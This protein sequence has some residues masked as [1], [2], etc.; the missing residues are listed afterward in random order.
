MKRRV[1]LG[2][3]ASLPLLGNMSP[4]FPAPAPILPVPK[5]IS[6]KCTTNF[7]LSQVLTLGVLEAYE[8]INE[9][10][11]VELSVS[12]DDGSV[13]NFTCDNKTWHYETR[14]CESHVV[15]GKDIIVYYCNQSDEDGHLA[16]VC[17]FKNVKESFGLKEL[18]L[19]N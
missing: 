12:Y 10:P 8:D 19:G 16:T 5:I 9:P 4:Y 3:I 11:K 1:F 7:E 13:R 6:L 14:K 15:I 18:Q 2:A 17:T